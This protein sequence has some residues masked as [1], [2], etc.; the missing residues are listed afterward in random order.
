MD[1]SARLRGKEL[2]GLGAE[3][4]ALAAKEKNPKER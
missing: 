1:Y 3:M 2:D 4:I